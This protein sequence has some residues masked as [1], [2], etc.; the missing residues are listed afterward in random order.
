MF[1]P[2]K[3]IKNPLITEK[4]TELTKENKYVFC[5]D[6]KANKY[7]IKKAIEEIYK[8]KVEKVYVL[9]IKPK[10]RRYRFFIEG[11]KSGYKK[12]IVKLKEGEKIAIT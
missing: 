5:V 7:Q 3:I 9:N 11:Y 4:G 1:D 2:Y 10:K 12:A 6:K 8:V